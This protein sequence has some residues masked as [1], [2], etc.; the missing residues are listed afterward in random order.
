MKT[1]LWVTY[2]GDTPYGFRTRKQLRWFIKEMRKNEFL[3]IIEPKDLK[4]YKYK[5]G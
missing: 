5:L 3:D 2:I 1:F 4:T